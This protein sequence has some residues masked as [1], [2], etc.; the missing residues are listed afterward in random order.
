MYLL[1]LCTTFLKSGTQLLGIIYNNHTQVFQLSNA[2]HNF[3]NLMMKKGAQYVL[4]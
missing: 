1:T 2:L 3:M 4:I